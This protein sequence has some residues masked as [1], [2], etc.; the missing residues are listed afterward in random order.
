MLQAGRRRSPKSPWPA[1]SVLHTCTATPPHSTQPHSRTTT[2]HHDILSQSY[3]QREGGCTG[4][5]NR[6]GVAIDDRPDAVT[7]P[8]LYEYNGHGGNRVPCLVRRSD[9]Q[10][11][12]GHPGHRPFRA[13]YRAL[14]GGDT[15]IC[16][17][18]D[19]AMAAS[20]LYRIRAAIERG[21]WSGSEW[22]SLHQLRRKW[23][24]RARG[25]DLRFMIAGNRPGRLP[26][27]SQRQLQDWRRAT[28]LGI[29]R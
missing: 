2:P 13:A 17:P 3:V 19:V 27:D 20:I 18:G 15:P 6:A 28:A 11:I 23:E 29:G 26:R 16:A 8:P 14:L 4:T 22:G 24:A 21:G 10:D 1:D 9:L 5:V 12:D 7:Q 25:E